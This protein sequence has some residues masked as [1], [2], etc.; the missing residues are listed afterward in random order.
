MS[1][2]EKSAFWIMFTISS[3]EF[4]SPNGDLSGSGL[5]FD[6]VFL[7]AV[8]ILCF[9]VPTTLA[10][11]ASTASGLSVERRITNTGFLMFGAVASS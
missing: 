5:C 1:Y 6:N 9:S 4:P 7:M 11:P 2:E 8:K 3:A 10:N